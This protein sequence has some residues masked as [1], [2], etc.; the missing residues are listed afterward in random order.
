MWW[1]TPHNPTAYD[2]DWEDQ[3]GQS[4]FHQW[5]LGL[6]LPIGILI[7]AVHIFVTRQAI[8]GD[9]N[10]N[11]DLRGRNA[12]AYGLAVASVAVMLHCHYF[13]GNLYNQAWIAV[14]GKILSIL[15]F[16]AG[17]GYLIFQVG[18]LGKH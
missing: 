9:D 8:M 3:P 11:L 13:W 16:I 17:L 6:G 10:V 15:C 4:G 1:R 14:L 18:V 2:D 12:I 5:I 7:Y